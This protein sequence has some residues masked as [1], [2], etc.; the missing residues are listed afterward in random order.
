MD[1]SQHQ[2]IEEV[3]EY[4]SFTSNCVPIYKEVSAHTS[5]IG[6]VNPLNGYYDW[7]SNVWQNT[8]LKKSLLSKFDLIFVL[9]DI[10]DKAIDSEQ[11][12]HI[13]ESR[14]NQYK[15]NKTNQK[16]NIFSQM[17][18]C[19]TND[20]QLINRFTQLRDKELDLIPHHLLKQYIIYAH[21]YVNPVLDEEATEL[22]ERFCTE[23]E[24]TAISRSQTRTIETLY[25]L[26]EARARLELRAV[27]TKQDVLDVMDIVRHS[28]GKLLR[29]QNAVHSL[30]THMS[31]KSSKK[32]QNT[33]NLLKG[34]KIIS[35]TTQQ[36]TFTYEE[37]VEI[38]NRFGIPF[39]SRDE[40]SVSVEKLN[41]QSFLLKTNPNNYKLI[42]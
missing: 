23:L 35:G 11:T 14:R 24:L 41:E 30:N 15:D 19:E 12:K 37:I 6:A 16:M 39:D 26:T 34:L 42:D 32:S 3:M 31:F 17:T 22:L 38:C 29:V 21:K 36:K 33:K 27:A 8:K 7:T 18:N 25:R 13:L 9:V 20:C 4:Q 10:P 1:F 2:V 28:V 40:I 5:I